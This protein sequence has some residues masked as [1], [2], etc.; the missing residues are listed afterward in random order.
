MHHIL[1]S[2]V[3][4]KWQRSLSSSGLKNSKP[5]T[6]FYFH[7]K[8]TA[9]KG[10]KQLLILRNSFSL[11]RRRPTLEILTDPQAAFREHAESPTEQCTTSC[12]VRYTVHSPLHTLC[13]S[14]MQATRG[15]KSLLIKC[16]IHCLI[17]K[18]KHRGKIPWLHRVRI[19]LCTKICLSE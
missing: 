16:Q 5:T 8:P 14:W 3:A 7:H 9:K 17:F 4:V 1:Q 18:L 19:L 11:S 12:F 15:P 10:S 2:Y 13:T 6:D